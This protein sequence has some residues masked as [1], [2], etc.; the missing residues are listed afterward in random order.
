MV[1]TKKIRLDHPI[2]IILILIIGFYL[3][4][5]IFNDNFVSKNNDLGRNYVPI[6]NFIKNSVINFQS[7]PLWRPDQ[8]MGEP[9]IGN[10]LSAL[11]YPINLIFLISPINYGSIIFSFIHFVIAGIST[12]YLAR[13]FSFNKLSS[14]STAIFYTFSIKMLLHLSA[15]HITM[16]AAFAFLPL[17]FLAIRGILQQRGFI[18]LIIGVIAMASM[19]ILYPTI[20]YYAAIFFI[21]YTIYFFSSHKKI[22]KKLSTYRQILILP[23]LIITLSAIQLLPQL[24]FSNFSNRGDIKLEDAALPLFNIKSFSASLFFP[25]LNINSF[26][27][28]SLLYLGLIP[29]VLALLSLKFLSRVKK[30]IVIIFGLASLLFV[31]GS[32]TPLYPFAFKFVPFLNLSR[33]ATRP[34]FV[35]VLVVALLAGFTIQK[36]K[37]K[38]LIAFLLSVF[39]FESLFIFNNAY[40]NLPQLQ[41]T[42]IKLY[43]YLSLDSD[44]FRVYCTTYCFNP[45]LIQ[46]Y[47]IQT[48]HGETPIQDKL[49]IDYLETAGN[50]DFDNFAVIFPPYQVWQ[51]DNP[52]QPN[53][54]FL[55]DANV[56]YIATTYILDSANFQFENKFEE[57]YLYKNL[58]YKPRI[59]FLDNSEVSISKYSPNKIKIVFEPSS[60]NRD[61]VIS[62]KYYPGWVASSNNQYLN[63]QLH[64]PIFRKISIPPKSDSVQLVYNPDS[65]N[66]G[67]VISIAT[68]LILI[69]LV[70]RYKKYI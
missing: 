13:S 15:G 46:K 50:Y 28:E 11:F 64:P 35:V 26:D 31:V 62:E 36:I 38:K 24:E 56:K 43:E 41:K 52:P 16:I 1:K 70:A 49:F 69:Y 65:F 29:S 45:Q 7:I 34:W 20:F 63:I 23:I 19:L 27:H 42:N 14:I 5:I 58:Q 57:I 25:Y 9:L 40:Q 22:Y 3:P 47:N 8:M 66:L 59:Y 6:Y 39:L 44:M 54:K 53:A 51:I 61:L 37:N 21:F 2:I 32:S 30:F 33:I 55:G 48:F 68:I 67:K 4:F 60:K 18:Y 10:G 12:F 17:S